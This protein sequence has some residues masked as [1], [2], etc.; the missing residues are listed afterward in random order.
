MKEKNLQSH[1]FQ[2]ESG[3]GSYKRF[4]ASFLHGDSEN[5]KKF[6]LTCKLFGSCDGGFYEASLWL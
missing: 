6:I 2:V 3:G 1:G 5:S 4:D